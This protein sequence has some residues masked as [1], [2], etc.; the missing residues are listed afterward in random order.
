MTSGNAPILR[1]KLR[2]PSPTD[3]AIDRPRLVDRLS[4]SEASVWIVTAPAG[5]GK[6]TLLAQALAGDDRATAWVSVDRAD[7]DAVRF[8]THVSA[9][10]GERLD[11]TLDQVNQALV[12]GQ[13]SLAID[14]LIASID[15][16]G[17]SLV[18]V[19]DDLHELEAQSVLDDLR[20]LVSLLPTGLT[21]AILTRSEPALPLARLRTRGEAVLIGPEELAFTLDE[22]RRALAPDVESGAITS[23]IAD[24]LI[25]VSDGW[26]A[27]L[28]LA[29]LAAR[30]GRPIEASSLSGHQPDVATYLAGEVLETQS[31]ELRDFLIATS[32]LDDL[33]P[34]ACDAVTQMDGSLK[35]LRSLVA[36]QVFTSLV[37]PDG[38]TFRYHR[39][40]REFLHSRLVE[41]DH[42]A[43]AGFH[44]RAADWFEQLG[45]PFPTITHAVAAGD[46]DRALAVL[47]ECYIDVAKQ[48]QID[49]LWSMVQTIGADRVLAHPELAPFPAWASLNQRRFDEIEPWLESIAL[50][51]DVDPDHRR[52]FEMHAA[53][54][55][56]HR[57]RHLGHLD[58]ALAHGR[59]AATMAESL[60]GTFIAP[61]GP[62]MLGVMLT[63]TGDNAAGQALREALDLLPASG[64]TSSEIM[65]HSF[66]GAT[67]DDVEAAD[68]H[69]SAALALVDTP[70]LVRFYKPAMAWFVRSRTG[71]SRRSDR[72][73]RGGRRT[74]SPVG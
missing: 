24:E 29:Q 41:R 35:L 33:T 25:A 50:V 23:K 12:D 53:V 13:V 68:Q 59:Q 28:R 72:R 20:R 17:K 52:I 6:T 37:D 3:G 2:A 32:I 26:A 71:P 30:G 65:A 8:W 74:S 48:G 16:Y 46:H 49:Q 67:V 10:L 56:S 62:L 55:R 58:E 47:A 11:D 31:D 38:P 40:F 42:E 54:L 73:R 4:T 64:D 22:G 43:V 66:L 39:L 36:G 69:A 63:L 34:G 18:L 60:P 51:D 57:D 9:A 45:D 19:L 7:N 44:A 21:V 14:Q 70:A 27:G 1:S 15:D 5:Y 61:S